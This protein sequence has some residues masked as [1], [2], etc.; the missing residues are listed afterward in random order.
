MKSKLVVFLLQL[1]FQ[2]QPHLG[3]KHYLIE[4]A[5]S[6]TSGSHDANKEE[7]LGDGKDHGHRNVNGRKKDHEH[8]KDNGH[9]NEH[10]QEKDH[11]QRKNHGHGKDHGHK[12]DNT[13]R[14][15]HGIE[16]G[17]G[18]DYELTPYERCIGLKALCKGRPTCL[19][20]MN[21]HSLNALCNFH[22]QCFFRNLRCVILYPKHWNF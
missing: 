17:H 21:T 13:H 7:D 1:L 19:E 12:N 2:V 5:P 14:M 10:K 6:S 18:W 8:G 11:G 3:G 16:H 22:S 15:K 9:K 20:A 4:L